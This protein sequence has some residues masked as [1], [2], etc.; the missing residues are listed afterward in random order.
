[1]VHYHHPDLINDHPQNTWDFIWCYP[2]N[3]DGMFWEEIPLCVH[4]YLSNH[5][6]VRLTFS[7]IIRSWMREALLKHRLAFSSN[8]EILNKVLIFLWKLCLPQK[9]GINLVGLIASYLPSLLYCYESGRSL[10]FWVSSSYY[11]VSQDLRNVAT[12]FA[13]IIIVAYFP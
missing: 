8:S 10:L 4:P 3:P 7:S 1:M 2:Q 11:F 9:A 13:Y 5:A 12:F 6:R